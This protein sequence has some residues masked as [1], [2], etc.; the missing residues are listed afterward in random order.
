[1]GHGR[2][3]WKRCLCYMVGLLIIVFATLGLIQLLT[4]DEIATSDELWNEERRINSERLLQDPLKFWNETR[5]SIEDP[6]LLWWTP[7]TGEPGQLR[8]CGRQKCFFTQ[9][10][11]FKDHPK[12]QAFLFYGSNFSPIDLPI[13]RQSH[14]Q[15][16]LLHEE[17]PKN[18]MLFSFGD[19]MQLFNHSATFRRHS[20]FPLTLQYLQSIDAL[21]SQNYFVP[22]L[23]KNDL[24]KGLAPVLYVHSDCDTPSGR[25]VYVKELMKHIKVDSYGA[26]LHNKDLPKH[27][28]DMSSG[29]NHDEFLKIVAQYKFTLA[30]ENSVC[31][32]YITEKLWRPLTVG[33]IPIY[34]GAPNVQDWLPNEESAILVD[35]FNGPLELAQFIKKLNADD[36]K[37]NE[38]LL[39]K[40]NATIV[41]E[42]LLSALEQRNWGIEADAFT[43]GN[44]VERF[45]CF[46]CDRIHV[47]NMVQ[48]HGFDSIIYTATED[49]YG[50]PPP[51]TSG[52]FDTKES[53]WNEQYRNAQVEA[54]VLKTLVDK[55]VNFTSKEYF[56]KVASYLKHF[57]HRQMYLK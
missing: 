53:W 54:Y 49:H 15:W 8:Q 39:H 32:D 7:F 1:M 14:H 19:A 43:K 35:N 23:K 5:K 36:G 34:F 2:P 41:N 17:S 12:L 31:E 18:K 21:I 45:E 29:M 22:V 10:R 38:Y 56:D 33:S 42:N 3:R 51:R 4:L 13:P 40:L 52:N 11:L 37:Y 20:D 46:L 48:R 57:N 47:L 50:C 30:F 28:Q 16:A 24:L 27:L 25:D 6:I 26:C 55:N 9:N 44:F